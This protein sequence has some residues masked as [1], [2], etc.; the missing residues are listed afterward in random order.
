LEEDFEKKKCALFGVRGKKSYRHLI[1]A[2]P[3]PSPIRERIAAIMSRK[4]QKEGR[5]GKKDVRRGERLFSLAVKKWIVFKESIL[6]RKPDIKRG[7]R[8]PRRQKGGRPLPSEREPRRWREQGQGEKGRTNEID[9]PLGTN[10]FAKIY[11]PPK[12]RRS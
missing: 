5:V 9:S 11:G 12:K 7:R 10:S 4:K 1:S 6:P 2:T 8:T 3:P